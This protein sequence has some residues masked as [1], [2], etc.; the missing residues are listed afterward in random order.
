MLKEEK[1]YA[2][3]LLFGEH[4]LMYGSQALSIPYFE[5]FGYFSFTPVQENSLDSVSHLRRFSKYLKEL[6]KLP[7]DIRSF[8]KDIENGLVFNTNIPLNYGLGSSGSL[9][10]AV[11]ARYG[12]DKISKET[13]GTKDLQR[14]KRLFSE[15]ESCFHGKSSGLDP[16]IC[17]LQKAITINPDGNL[18]V[19]P[20][21]PFLQKD[22]GAVFLLNSGQPGETQKMV[23]DFSVRCQSADFMKRVQKEL[24]PTSDR[25]IQSWI[26]GD[27]EPFF[28]H[29]KSLSS[30]TLN[31]QTAMVPRGFET[32]WREGL[33]NN[34]YY[35]KL[36]GS[37]GGGMILG[38]T[39]QWENAKGLLK[40]YPVHFVQ[41]L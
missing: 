31:L 23:Q 21:E 12:T 2:K 3:I 10:A 7:L 5:R 9:V 24:I 19:V 28:D 18:S 22:K 39:R 35:L 25:C 33:E 32:I 38:F 30:I 4:I 6:P 40:A 17:Y 41:Q 26:S 16:L 11:Y 14:L 34:D 29:V 36:C 27:K 13:T 37:G 8:E 1:F 20:G 15:M